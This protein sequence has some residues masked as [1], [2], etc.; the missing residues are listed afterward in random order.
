ML[1]QKLKPKPGEVALINSPKEIL[2]EFKSF[3]PKTSIS[4]G[5]QERFDFVLFFA[6]NSG[7]LNSAWKRIVPALKT[8]AAFW[9][10]YPKKSSGIQSDLA[11]MTGGWAVYAGSPWQPVASVSL[12][13]T[14]TGI[15]FK[16]SPAIEEK[17]KERVSEEIH[18]VDGTL[19][20]DRINRVVYPPKDL[21][22]LLFKHPAAKVFFEGLSFTHKK[23]YVIWIVEAKKKETRD[24]RLASAL[25]RM[26]SERRTP[27]GK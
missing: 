17:R 3:K 13:D 25:E 27:S 22:Q 12:N 26:V 8:D 14:W 10:G 7:E 18:D 19:V 15:R 23:E 11:G 2:A 4:P 5:A 16:Y 24:K 21:E 6:L 20:V 1:I 9:V